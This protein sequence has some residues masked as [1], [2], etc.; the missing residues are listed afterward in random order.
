MT[1][2]RGFA[3]LEAGDIDKA[4]EA[5]NTASKIMPQSTAPAD[6]L[7]QLATVAQAR[8]ISG[9]K[10]AAEQAAENED[11]PTAVAQFELLL[12][13]D[14][15]LI[16]A[17][18]GLDQARR[19]QTLAEA[20]ARHLGDSGLMSDDNELTNAKQTLIAA[21]RVKNRGPRLQQQISDL[22]HLISLARIPIPV[23]LTSDSVT[24]VTVYK[25]GAFGTLAR[26]ELSL[27]PG[28]YTIVGKRPGY[29]DV[30]RRLTLAGGDPTQTVHISCDEKI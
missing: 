28:S 20:M 22:S 23:I 16:F 18:Q 11:W 1:M 26:H 12:G 21:S 19:R 9:L 14:P 8:Q 17:R 30:Q 4:R 15:T 3:N 7:T 2:S 25:V 10:T 13:V 29:R 5:F 6:G 24:S 27:F